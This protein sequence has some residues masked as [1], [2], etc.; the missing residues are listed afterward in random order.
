V[1]T[2]QLEQLLL[3]DNNLVGAL[4]AGLTDSAVVH[5]DLGNNQ[6]TGALPADWGDLAWSV[7]IVEV[8]SNHRMPCTVI[9]S[10]M[11]NR[12]VVL[13]NVLS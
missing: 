2:S 7:Q 1:L 8:R 5:L 11:A 4:P 12:S 13:I 9:V 3:S 6:L 10:C